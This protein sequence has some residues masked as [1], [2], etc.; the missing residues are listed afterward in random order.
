MLPPSPRLPPRC[1][2]RRSTLPSP[3]SCGGARAAQ[4]YILIGE[5]GKRCP[6]LPSKSGRTYTIMGKDGM[7]TILTAEQY[8]ALS[9]T[10]CYSLNL[11]EASYPG[12]ERVLL[13]EV[14]AE[15]L[16]MHDVQDAEEGVLDLD[17]GLLAA[18]AFRRK[19]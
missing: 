9:G 5:V 16:H 12:Y 17:A 1:K 2:L 6:P 18:V 14:S 19:K 13:P 8:A 3:P 4:E 7:P 11:P 15:L 10:C